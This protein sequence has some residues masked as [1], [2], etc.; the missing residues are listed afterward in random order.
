MADA[1]P[2]R[3]GE[4]PRPEDACPREDCSKLYHDGPCTDMDGVA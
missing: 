3:K 2:S 1:K 4:E